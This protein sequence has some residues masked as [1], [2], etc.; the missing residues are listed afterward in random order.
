MKPEKAKELV[1]EL[2]AAVID[3]RAEIGGPDR[4]YERWAREE[5]NK[6]KDK[7]IKAMSTKEK[8]PGLPGSS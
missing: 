2:I 7:L 1:E 5:M 6:V 3:W 4:H 8:S